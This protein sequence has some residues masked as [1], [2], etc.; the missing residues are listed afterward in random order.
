MEKWAR[1]YPD[2]DAVSRNVLTTICNTYCLVNLVDNDY[3]NETCLWSI[4]EQVIML[5]SNQC[6][7]EK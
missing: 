1:V 3:P 5:D 7:C 4:L 6:T 2:D